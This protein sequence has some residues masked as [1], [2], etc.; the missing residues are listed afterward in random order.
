MRCP[1]FE[2]RVR[3]INDL[4][5]IFYKIQNAMSKNKQQIE[6]QNLECTKWLNWDRYAKWIVDERIIE[7][8]Y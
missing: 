6:Q 7:F 5:D 3:G 4:K 2:K 1:F 8:I